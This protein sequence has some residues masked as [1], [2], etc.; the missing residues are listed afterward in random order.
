V[1]QSLVEQ[2][3]RGF[4]HLL[5]TDLIAEP[6]VPEIPGFPLPSAVV[7]AP[8][9]QSEATVGEFRL[10]V[11]ETADDPKLLLRATGGIGPNADGVYWREIYNDL[12]RD[13]PLWCSSKLYGV[14]ELRWWNSERRT[15][16]RWRQLDE[17]VTEIVQGT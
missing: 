17:T 9:P 4:R 14:V 5:G 2:L 3:K 15:D 8:T 7:L 1:K 13:P 12:R 10:F 16:T 11:W 6:T